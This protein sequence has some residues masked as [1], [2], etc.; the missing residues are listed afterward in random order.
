MSTESMY[1]NQ[2]LAKTLRE[3]ADWID[4]NMHAIPAPMF[5]TIA[6]E[7]DDPDQVATFARV[8]TATGPRTDDDGHV[9]AMKW[10]GQM[11]ALKLHAPG[12]GTL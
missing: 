9:F 8:H 1:A 7:T 6:V 5:A 3:V 4:A 11:V 10:F 2:H 12:G